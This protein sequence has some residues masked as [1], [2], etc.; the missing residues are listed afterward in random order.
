MTVLALL[1]LLA[2]LVGAAVWAKFHGWFHPGNA[3]KY[4][5]SRL[6]P[7][8]ESSLQGKTIFCLGSSV[9]R[10]MASRGV[11]FV[12]YIARLDGCIMIR[13][14]VSAS[15]LAD[16]SPRSYLRRLRRHPAVKQP[17]DCFLCQLSTNDATFCSHMGKVSDSYDPSSFDSRTSVGGM[18]TIIAFARE[19]W[20]C[21][22]VFFTGTRFD[23]P[24]YHKE[25]N[26]LLELEEKWNITVIDLWHDE[27]LNQLTQ[28]ERRLYM[29]DGIHPTMAGY[30]LW[31]TP[32]IRQALRKTL[33]GTK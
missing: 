12:D 17:I 32:V 22:I 2:A 24:R 25:V 20:G 9:T 5:P 23:N 11:S 7:D 26:L 10:G 18:E 21:P 8:P 27:K 16:T 33:E 13:E 29:N 30:L 15:T 6:Q 3:M 19:T 14:A 1:L 31:W 28:E 4:A